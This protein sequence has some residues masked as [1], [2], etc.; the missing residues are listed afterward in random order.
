MRVISELNRPASRLAVYASS[1]FVASDGQDSLPAGGYP[2][3][4]GLPSHK[5]LLKGFGY[6][7]SPHVITFPFPRFILAPSPTP[8]PTPVSPQKN[9]VPYS[10]YSA[11]LL[12]E[13]RT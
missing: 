3:P 5:A 13:R 8:P 6:S 9:S 11:L 4:G 7:M 12:S 10:S 2:L 1:A